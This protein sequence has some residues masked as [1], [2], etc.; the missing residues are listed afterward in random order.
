MDNQ[1]LE[2]L[3][4]LLSRELSKYSNP[5]NSQKKYLKRI[6]DCYSKLQ[7]EYK[8]QNNHYFSPLDN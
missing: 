8:A 2:A 7:E 1:T 6:A 3:L 4:N 5:I